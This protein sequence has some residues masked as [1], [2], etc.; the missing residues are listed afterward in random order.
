[1]NR[2]YILMFFF[3]V[4]VKAFA[5]WNSYAKV[6]SILNE[7][8]VLVHNPEV[9]NAGD[10]VLLYQTKG[11]LVSTQSNTTFGSVQAWNQTGKLEKN[12]IQR[13]IRDT[14][15]LYLKMSIP[16]DTSGLQLITYKFQSLASI[17]EGP[18]VPAWNGQTGGLLFIAADRIKMASSIDLSGKGFRGG[19]KSR[20][21]VECDLQDY[22][23]EGFTDKAGS[24]GEGVASSIW[25]HFSGRGAW[26]N[27]GGGGNEHNGGGGGGA[28]AG[29]GGIGGKQPN[30]S[31]CN[32][33]V[34]VGGL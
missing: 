19:I 22:S 20:V 21:F 14:V 29:E 13:V 33:Q 34:L 1:M 4:Q 15:F 32:P 7:C 9:L 12:R 11:A 5:Q 24:K 3:L 17:S 2:L 31:F 18:D 30:T 16:F 28:G 8:V 6:V 23:F 26:A 10:S 25:K 27:G